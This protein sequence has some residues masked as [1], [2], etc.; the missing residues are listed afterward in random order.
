MDQAGVKIAV[1]ALTPFVLAPFVMS[2]TGGGPIWVT[3]TGALL[4]LGWIATIAKAFLRV[5]RERK[6]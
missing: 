6:P 2:V 3:I 5:R 1:A 4:A